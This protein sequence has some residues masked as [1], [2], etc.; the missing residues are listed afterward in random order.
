MATSPNYNQTHY[1]M[2]KT[3]RILFALLA[4]SALSAPAGDVI[5]LN[6]HT[7]TRN[8]MQPADAAGAPGTRVTNWNNLTGSGAV[9]VV[10]AAGT[11][12]NDK[13][14]V[15]PDLQAILHPVNNY[16]DRYAATTNDDKMFACI[17]DKQGAGNLGG[18]GY[19]DLTNIP[20]ANYNIR[21]YHLPD[22]GTGAA[23]TR[24]GVWVVTNSPVGV[25]R[26][27][28]NSQSNDVALTIYNRPANTG[29][30]YVLA[31]TASIPSGGASW[32]DIGGGNYAVLSGLTN[33][34]CRIWFSGLGNGNGSRDDAGNW[35][36][37]GSTAI[38]FKISGFQ[39]EEVVIGTATNLHLSGSV[40]TLYAN[41]PGSL[42][43]V[44]IA[45]FNN[46]TSTDV[47]YQQGITF[48]SENPSIFTVSSTGFLTP[49]NPG[50]ANLV[51]NYQTT[52]LTQA[53]TVLG[54]IALRTPTVANTNLYSGNNIGDV[55]TASL[56]ADF[57]PTLTNINVTTWNSTAFSS[58]AAGVV[59]V[60][61]NGTVT[62]VAPGSFN[63]IASFAGLSAT[64][65]NAGTVTAYTA[66]GT[67]PTLSFHLGSP[68]ATA[69]FKD[70]A[71]VGGARV[72]YWN[73]MP[74]TGT[75]ASNAFVNPL[76][77]H[78]NIQSGTIA[79]VTGKS[80]SSSFT[81]GTVTTN[82]GRIF[83]SIYDAG[84]NNPAGGPDPNFPNTSANEGII[85]V[86]N[87]P[88]SLYDVYFYCFN[89]NAALTRPGHFTVAETGETRWR[90]NTATLTGGVGNN[91]P[92][93][94]TGTGYLEAVPIIS[95]G[96]IPGFTV[97]GT[98]ANV[99]AGNYVKFS[100]LTAPDLVVAWGADSTDTVIDADTVTRLRIAGFQ[101]V[102][103]DV[104]NTVAT[105]VQLST[106][107]PNLLPG[108][109]ATFQLTVLASYNDG[110]SGLNVSSAAGTTYQ[111]TD[112]NIFTVSATGTVTPGATP[113]TAN[114]IVTYVN[115]VSSVSVTQ[116]VTVLTPLSVK[117]VAA[118]AALYLDSV[119]GTTTAQ[120]KL[121][122]TFLGNTNVDVSGFTGV[123]F[124][125]FDASVASVTSA[126]VATPIAL[127]LADIGGT[128]L[129]VNYVSTNALPVRSINDPAIMTHRYS[130]RDTGS[131]ITDSIGGA[132]GT[133][134]AATGG[135]NNINLDGDRANFPGDATYVNAPY[136]SLPAGLVSSH[137]SITVELWGG[138]NQAKD[139]G[140]FFVAGQSSKGTNPR[141]SGSGAN[142]ST[143]EFIP[144]PAGNTVPS[145]TVRFTNPTTS[146][147]MD[148]TAPFGTGVERHVV[149]VYAPDSGVM[150]L[151]IDGAL[152]DSDVPVAG[153]TLGQF[154]D[155]VFWLGVSL[156]DDNTLN[157]WISEMRI[158]EGAISD[159]A[160]AASYAAGANVGLPSLTPPSLS[161][162]PAG[163]NVEVS[164]P[165]SSS[166][167]LKSNTVLNG[168]WYPA[169]GTP[170]VVGTNKV[171][172]V[173]AN[174][175]NVFFILQ[176]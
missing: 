124:G 99:P 24:G 37:G 76:D 67:I 155:Q 123:T 113:G 33:N 174:G 151:Y 52:S 126:G 146:L 119:L 156:F 130:F 128:Y 125:D 92:D 159:A 160:V 1:R 143:F 82:E 46:G 140:R 166:Y 86:T 78:G 165:A 63:L 163:A 122:A 39:I 73:A 111:S 150:K 79:V 68:S 27:Y 109:P 104:A 49:G 135:F 96:S 36:N 121:L 129:G 168:V 173:P 9:D 19:L 171:L 85:A 45:D 152:V 84:L 142:F 58:T 64:N 69:N 161:I 38:R 131:T 20:Y 26:R 28:I 81:T 93:E 89:D 22:G 117:A 153:K 108:N 5:S 112:A 118:P 66:P 10:A 8:L 42:G 44:V 21:C 167:T 31:S 141:N 72:G 59:S 12:I 102:N 53:V 25:Q 147:F 101:I 95:G 50:T 18:F 17:I 148:G 114:L 87:V 145:T 47:T 110:R 60:T 35:V 40:P 4:A 162:T 83:R 77:Y 170:A 2:C 157:G 116:A 94:T 61:A 34:S 138:Q 74:L 164:W 115:N 103:V 100:N 32:S 154:V 106:P 57:S 172:T 51:V 158:Y 134:F 15:V 14:V 56:F 175:S 16:S 80:T 54:P 105:N 137:G 132:D 29:A 97:P 144:K 11:L 23:N 41:K 7:A 107:V 120:V 169:S 88:Y 139:W 55:T 70:L 48:T 127:G 3:K 30:G 13:G 6:I 43:I 136:I 75:A 71:G 91:I 149:M 62:A 176:Q 65:N 98:M 133:V 90:K